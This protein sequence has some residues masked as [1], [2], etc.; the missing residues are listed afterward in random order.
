MA[1]VAEPPATNE[2]AKAP[3]PEG[4][5]AGSSGPPPAKRA[6]TGGRGGRSG[7]GGRGGLAGKP[8][9]PSR[10]NPSH[11]QA[12]S[13]Y[14][15]VVHVVGAAGEGSAIA[16]RVRAAEALGRLCRH[17]NGKD[18][19][20][21]QSETQTALTIP[22]A[23]MR[24]LVALMLCKW[25]QSRLAAEDAPAAADATA[26]SPQVQQQLLQALATTASLPFYPISSHH[27]SETETYYS[28]MQREALALIN[29]CMQAG[30]LLHTPGDLPVDQLNAE[31][32]MQ[33]LSTVPDAAQ[34]D[35]PKERLHSI[36]SSLLVYEQYL[37][38]TSLAC[39]AAAVVHCGC[40]PPK[41]NQVIQPLMAAV[42]KEPEPEIQEVCASALAELIAACTT[43]SPSPNDKLV[44]NVCGM[45]CG[46]PAHTPLVTVLDFKGQN[47]ADA[48]LQD[49]LQSHASAGAT[50]S[51]ITPMHSM[52]RL[53]SQPSIGGP[54]MPP[55]SSS[56]KGAGRASTAALEKQASQQVGKGDTHATT[57]AVA[58]SAAATVESAAQE[59]SP[60]AQ[61]AAVARSGAA[62]VLRALC[63]RLGG[64]L[65]TQLPML[66]DLIASPL[67]AVLLQ[68]QQQQQQQQNAG[69]GALG[70]TPFGGAEPDGAVVAGA[71]AS[72]HALQIIRLVGPHLDA[73]LAPSLESLLPALCA[74]VRHVAHPV[75]TMASSS[76]A[77]VT[78]AWL[79]QLMPPLLR[80]LVPLLQ[81]SDAVARLGGVLG[82]SALV[83]ALGP[84]LV[85]YAVLLVVPLLRCMS[86]PS[87]PV[88]L[89]ASSCFG[90]L[91]ALLP[92]AQGA[93]TPAGLDDAQ[94]QTVQ[95]DTAFLMQG[96]GKTLQAS[97]I[98]AAA[99]VEQ[100]QGGQDAG[101]PNVCLVVCPSTLVQHWAHEVNK[102]IDKSA[103]RPVGYSGNPQERASQQAKLDKTLGRDSASP[104]MLVISYEHLRADIEWV[105]S[106]EWLYCILDEG[107]TIKSHK[108]R[109]AQ[110]CKRVIACHR[111]ILSGTPIQNNVLEL[112]SLFDFLLPGFL[113][114]EREFY[115]RYGKA[116]QAAR[117]S[118][119]G[120]REAETG[121]LAVDAL[122]K[123]VMP[124][125]LRR[126]KAQV[127]ADL[128][129]K[130]IQDVHCQMS[131][132]QRA[133]YEDFKESQASGEAASVLSSAAASA[134]D[135]K[136][137]MHVFQ[138]L[139]Y[140]RKL[141][142]HPAFVLDVRLEE[143]RN[144]AAE[145][146]GKGV[147]SNPK[148]GLIQ[149][150][151]EEASAGGDEDL[152]SGGGGGH[153]LLVFAQ[154]KGMLERVER[155]VLQPLGVSF[156]RIDGS[157]D[158]T[159]R[160]AVVQRFNSDPTIDVLLLTTSVGG[161][162]LN[163]TSADTVV[164]LE[165]DWNPMKDLQAM[166]RAHR[167]G[168]TRTV[169]VYRLLMAD[170]LEEK[171]MG[172]QQFKMD[173]AN[174]VVNQDNISLS[175]MDTGQL[176][177]LFG[178]QAPPSAGEA[179]AGA[180]GAPPSKPAK[181][182]GLEAM[183]AGM[184]ELWD[185]KEYEQQFDM[186]SFMEKVGRGQR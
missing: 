171:V 27:Y 15:P 92:L 132:L 33:L 105:S 172:L 42:R 69:G 91:V 168:Q 8:Q 146:L 123:Q 158:A 38:L 144:A 23:T 116:L 95:Q 3:T 140:M 96:L 1:V 24:S 35:G 47:D 87:P 108:S 20:F 156:L 101:R 88:R 177:D 173:M 115:A 179:G 159:Q 153:R 83:E 66:W 75:R 128:P 134:E 150:E 118:K 12:G 174:T 151:G 72:V 43:R 169:N 40:L 80:N 109:T 5:P 34:V 17:I 170:T 119:K 143:H 19:G 53:Q 28:Q 163:L 10:P 131:P 30:W 111:L 121:V 57:A 31:H 46:D 120:S 22:S 14:R 122:H 186:Q 125:I 185:E 145:V 63:K 90:A 117:Y 64:G 130:I 183:L 104:N 98:M 114:P 167:L 79:S 84:R 26:A 44:R 74:C 25:V 13:V 175:T 176:L 7:P 62:A 60:A 59:V 129:P 65:W 37:H 94:M 89:Q 162:G 86:D 76:M 147:V 68:Q 45:A 178:K 161:L 78:D 11:Q 52:K 6:R 93:P 154:F 32:I 113:G 36:A 102:F 141:C 21:A 124:F 51:G 39:C 164:F 9:A 107:H 61:A 48:Q 58:S 127:L 133:L 180:A 137:N 85:P 106:R 97:S 67:V 18:G 155:D 136:G 4:A 99:L 71:Q 54:S 149:G 82:G 55:P 50:T 165:H 77:A 126:T 148:C 157:V 160:F 112:W 29:A 110:A 81:S 103:L 73:S 182:T 70:T 41:L 181:A 152:A 142:S 184:G 56:V 166:D 16:M 2:A 100:A 135:A 138:S 139:H 49:R